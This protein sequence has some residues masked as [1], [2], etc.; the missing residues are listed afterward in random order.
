MVAISKAALRRW[1]KFVPRSV[2][3]VSL[4]AEG[5]DGPPKLVD[6]TAF[7]YKGDVYAHIPLPPVQITCP[8]Q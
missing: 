3:Y 5:Q 2:A 1:T 4:H 8:Q 6:Q 7:A